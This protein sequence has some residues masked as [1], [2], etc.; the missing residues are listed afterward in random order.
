MSFSCQFITAVK[1]HVQILLSVLAELKL[2][3]M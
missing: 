3:K 2:T 1:A